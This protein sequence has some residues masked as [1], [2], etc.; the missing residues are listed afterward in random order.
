MKLRLLT[1]KSAK[2]VQ[3]QISPGSGDRVYKSKKK[4]KKQKKAYESKK[5]QIRNKKNERTKKHTK[6]TTVVSLAITGNQKKIPELE[7]RCVSSPQFN[8]EQGKILDHSFRAPP[9]EIERHVERLWLE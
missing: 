7:T 6:I 9:N 3:K 8:P 5:K 4:C 1:N 2:S